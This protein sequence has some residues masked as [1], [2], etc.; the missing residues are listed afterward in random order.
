MAITTNR[1]YND[2]ALGAAFSNLASAFMPPGGGDLAGYASAAATREEA[3]RLADLFRYAQGPEF[4]QSQ[5]DRMGQAT[6]QWTPSTGYYGVDTAAATARRGQDVSAQNALDVARV[7]ND[8]T[9]ARQ[10]AEPL[11]VG[12]G[13]TAY[14]PGQTAAATGLAPTLP[15]MFTLAPGERA[16]LPGGQAVDGPAKPMTDTEVKGAILGGLPAADQR[17]AVIGDVPVETI[18]GANGP[19]I[20]A[21]PDAIGQTPA[22]TGQVETQNYQTPDGRTGTAAFVNGRWVDTQSGAPLPEKSIT[23]N[24][25]LQGGQKETGIAPTTANT[26]DFNKQ[27]AE[28]DYALQRIDAFEK[29]LTA[30]PGVLGIAG[31]VQGFV[32]DAQQGVSELV[33]LY[34]ENK[35]V[36]DISDIA[37]MVGETAKVQGWNPAIAQARLMA[38]EMAYMEIK[39]QDPS[40]EV[41]V[42]ELERVLPL[43][44]GG[45]A[46]NQ[47][48]L[49]ALKVTRQRW[50][51]RQAAASAA[52]GRLQPAAPEAPAAPA[53]PAAG[54]TRL[55]FDE[56]GNPV[57]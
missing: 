35:V 47:P 28:A 17:N 40:G 9:M 24:S 56:N 46:G 21:R 2:P 14:L 36:Q 43:F 45:I 48:V 39:S 1:V 12:A 30:N 54:N 34:G 33:G 57:Q 8:A 52:L 32:Q 7:N 4:N 25:S 31:T 23:Y 53:A 11:L 38:L 49:D 22:P 20:V 27:I 50:V 16:V 29:H 41:N 13:E 5:F 42:R 44:N 15:G 10:M 51:D 18:M 55:R 6:G 3:A 26:T 37:A 19:M